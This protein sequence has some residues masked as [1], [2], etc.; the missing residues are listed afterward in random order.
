MK[1]GIIVCGAL[2]EIEL[3]SRSWNLPKDADI[4]LLTWDMTEDAHSGV[5]RPID[6]TVLDKLPIDFASYSVFNEE[7]IYPF[8]KADY[9]YRVNKGPWFWKHAYEMFNRLYDRVIVLRPDIFL[10]PLVEDAW[11]VDST[12]PVHTVNVRDELFFVVN[13][14]GFEFL[15]G[16]YD[17]ASCVCGSDQNAHDMI[18]D[19]YKAH[20][21]RYSE[22]LS[23]RFTYF[24]ARPN[25]RRWEHT[26]LTQATVADILQDTALWNSGV[27]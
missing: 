26:D 11:S 27:R 19:W 4:H 21:T 25:S 23:K 7:K 10:W 18:E 12:I 16:V 15:S 24:L 9:L 6:I 20:E 2:R 17:F 3:C 1:T 22:S 14:E 5:Y 13:E 8:D